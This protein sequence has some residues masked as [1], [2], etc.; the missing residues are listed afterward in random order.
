M[1]VVAEKIIL[2]ND[3]V[4]NP[5]QTDGFEFVEFASPKKGEDLEKTFIDMG[6][7][8]VAKHRSKEV[9]LYRQGEVNFII[10]N[11]SNSFAENFANAHGPSACAMAIRVKDAEF[12]LNRAISLGAKPYVS[13]VR[14][15][16][17][18]I[19]A[20]YGVGG[21][22]IYFVDRYQ[23][24][25]IYDNDFVFLTSSNLEHEGNGLK[26]IDHLTN[27]VY[28]GEMSV[29]V[30]FYQKLFNFR[31]IRYFQINGKKTGLL[32]RA[33]TSPCNK[34]RIPINEPTEDAS[35]IAE[36]LR[37]YKGEGIQHIALT[38]NNIIS[39]IAAIQEN[40]IKFL[41]ITPT[42]YQ[43]IKERFPQLN[44]NWDAIENYNVLIDGEIDGQSTQ[45]LYQIFTETVIGPIFFELIQREGHQGFGEGNFSALFES[46]ERD[47]ME[48]GII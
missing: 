40:G 28:K 2:D 36:Y 13:N 37:E 12:A 11:E 17:L 15:G 29:W 45:M 32:S 24:S 42:Y 35:Q 6:F 23:N 27:N 20:I 33:M 43:V 16:E 30:D 10:N 1:S 44:V 34:I 22:L 9:Y 26:L 18:K 3:S 46:M 7:K 5:M 38:T 48:R 41:K 39:S 8:K 25:T 21:S 4:L 14:P 47:Q 19:P 31:E